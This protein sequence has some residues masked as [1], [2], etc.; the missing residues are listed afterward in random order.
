MHCTGCAQLE[1]E[2][3]RLRVELSKRL[4]VE[5]QWNARH[6]ANYKSEPKKKK[7]R[8]KAHR[9]FGGGLGGTCRAR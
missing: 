1:A 8:G 3:A 2:V 6:A 5:D 4:T 7:S 9:K